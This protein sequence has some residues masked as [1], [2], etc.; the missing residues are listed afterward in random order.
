MGGNDDKCG[1]RKLELGNS[2]EREVLIGVK[3]CQSGHKSK[4]TEN[5]SGNLSERC[6]K[7][8]V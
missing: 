2:N 8:Q 3:H 6:L 4:I 1:D 7:S 5:P